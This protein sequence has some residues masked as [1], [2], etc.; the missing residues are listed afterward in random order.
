[1]NTFQNKL[2]ELRKQKNY[3]QED[4]ANILHVSRQAISKWENGIS[5]PSMD[6]LTSIAKVFNVSIDDLFNQN[7]VR[8]ITFKHNNKL[9]IFK[10]VTILI[11]FIGLIILGVSIISLL[12]ANKAIQ[13]SGSTVEG[14]E[15]D[16]QVGMVIITS[17]KVSEVEVDVNNLA[18]SGY[19]YHLNN[20]DYGVI[21]ESSFGFF[22]VHN[23]GNK[24]ISAL[25]YIDRNKVNFVMIASIFQKPDNSLYIK[26]SHWTK[27]NN[28]SKL[29]LKTEESNNSKETNFEIE[30]IMV[31][32]L[33]ESTLYVYDINNNKIDEKI[34][35][36][37]MPAYKVP[38]DSLYVVIENKFKNQSGEYYYIRD[39]ITSGDIDVSLS[40]VLKYSNDKG[41]VFKSF[42]LAPITFNE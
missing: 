16:F 42:M 8:N 9:K 25:I 6:I 34:I 1:M 24:K 2:F 10:K 14:V 12:T 36:E 23:Y 15:K 40:Y 19:A 27:I 3:T 22:K 33:E 31:N 5:Y 17:D 28:I 4:L 11:S 32:S 38:T 30:I 13:L 20:V 26:N 7:D 39:V 41:V 37:N 18:T 21:E 29:S 35:E